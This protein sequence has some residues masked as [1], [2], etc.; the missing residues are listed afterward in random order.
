[1][2]GDSAGVAGYSITSRGDHKVFINGPYLMGFTT[3]FRMGQL[4]RYKFNPTPCSTWDLEK[5]MTTTFI[6]EVREC[7]AKNGYDKKA[8][9]GDQQGGT[10]LVA[11]QGRIFYVSDDF[12]L[13][14]NTV[15]YD[16]CGC[17]TDLALGAMYA[18]HKQSPSVDPE[19]I[20]K[21]ALGAA[22]EYSAGVRPPFNIL[23]I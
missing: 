7:F 1:M 8:Q 3:S 23:S 10:F 13:G 5:H 21:L 17:G 4:L 9:Q 15:P 22:A 14:W 20:V 18:L 6:D 11:T 16:A 19:E 2:G 12:Q